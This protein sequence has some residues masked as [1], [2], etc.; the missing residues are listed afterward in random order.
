MT[1]A[2]QL[3]IRRTPSSRNPSTIDL[4][5]FL[6]FFWRNFINSDGQKDYGKEFIHHSDWILGLG[7]REKSNEYIL[8]GREIERRCEKWGVEKHVWIGNWSEK[9]KKERLCQGWLKGKVVTVSNAGSK[10][11]D[12][13]QCCGCGLQSGVREA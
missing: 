9:K 10:V 3:L 11:C 7:I 2:I 1:N 12:S 8:G 13:L 6:I 5:Q 4:L